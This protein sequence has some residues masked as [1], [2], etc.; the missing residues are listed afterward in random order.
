MESG[1]RVGLC[2]DPTAGDECLRVEPRGG[3]RALTH[4]VM[5]R[6]VFLD[7]LTGARACERCVLIFRAW[8]RCGA[9]KWDG[10]KEVGPAPLADAASRAFAC[11]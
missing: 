1:R 10:K 8:E 5:P 9:R 11:L 7:V 2:G 6:C 3:L 4:S